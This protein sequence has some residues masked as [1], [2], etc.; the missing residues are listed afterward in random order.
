MESPRWHCL[1][2][3]NIHTSRTEGIFSKSPPLWKFQISLI[4]FFKCFG[5]RE[6]PPPRK[7]QSLLWEEYMYGYF[8]ELHINLG[9]QHCVVSENI[10]TIPMEGDQGAWQNSTGVQL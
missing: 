7:F 2:S 6:P 9:T 10:Q 5:P 8:L 4:H 3:E 1:V